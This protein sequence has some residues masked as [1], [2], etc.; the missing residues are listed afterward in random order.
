MYSGYTKPPKTDLPPGRYYGKYGRRLWHCEKCDT[1]FTPPEESCDCPAEN[2][3]EQNIAEAQELVDR[4]DAHYGD[5][6][7]PKNIS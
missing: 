2:E 5:G 3:R 7:E 1:D 4:I 6:D